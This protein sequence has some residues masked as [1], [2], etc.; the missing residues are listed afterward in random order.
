MSK[1]KK[2]T[3]FMKELIRIQ[4]LK[5]TLAC[6][7]MDLLYDKIPTHLKTGNVVEDMIKWGKGLIDA[8]EPHVCM[9]KFQ[10][11]YYE[12]IDGGD[13]IVHQLVDY[14]LNKY[15]DVLVI[16]DCKRGD[17]DRTQ[18]CYFI[19][20]LVKDQFQGMNFNP[21]MGESCYSSLVPEN[22]DEKLSNG[23]YGVCYTSNPEGR[24]MQDVI[25][26]NGEPYYAHVARS[27]LE[28][29]KKYGMTEVTGLV[30][31]AA[32]EP[33]KG[34]GNIFVDQFKMMNRIVKNW[35][36]KLVPGI[37]TQ[38]GFILDTVIHG[39]LGW[40]TLVL[41]SSSAL[42]FGS[43]GE[44]FEQVA[45][46]KAIEFTEKIREALKILDDKQKRQQ[47][48][49]ELFFQQL[50]QEG[51]YYTS[52]DK[53][54][55]RIGPMVGYAG[56][57]LDQNGSKL[58]YVGDIFANCLRLLRK[59]W[60]LNKL[61]EMSSLEVH[62]FLLEKCMHNEVNPEFVNKLHF[63]GAPMGGIPVA[64]TLANL[65][66]FQDEN[67]VSPLKP[68]ISGLF[69]YFDKEVTAVATET[70]REQTVL[71]DKSFPIESG[72]F[73]V[74]VEDVINNL[75]TTREAVYKIIEKGGIPVLIFC[76]FN[77]SN[78]TEFYFNEVV[79]GK[80]VSIFIPIISACRKELPEYKQD[81][82]EIKN[83]IAIEGNLVKQ[84]KKA[85]GELITKMLQYLKFD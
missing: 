58:Q 62:T 53:D 71:N 44:D 15:P 35:L 42:T 73:Y 2:I 40:G 76:L 33:V 60:I 84:P 79:N 31:A 34:S 28:W 55:K 16:L 78:T 54:G 32:Y 1:V 39:F 50:N 64:L 29:S 24:Q 26:E 59:P 85:W 77:R 82:P 18:R 8:F 5:H 7:G 80:R 21:Y 45:K 83:Y 67:N 37:G 11:A 51:G 48:Q 36:W 68:T 49:N 46:Q 43:I 41:C 25:M 63:Y 75:K 27:I 4:K 66:K 74:S 65:V 47:E 17:I 22:Q 14:I 9:F 30:I 57:Y 20:H 38:G 19:A 61:V 70:L 72:E 3:N 12:Q 52:L 13:E 56:T 23:I 69:G 10:S 6:A 81:N